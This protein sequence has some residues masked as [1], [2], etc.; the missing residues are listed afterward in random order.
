MFLVEDAFAG[1][2]EDGGVAGP[3]VLEPFGEMEG[4][5]FLLGVR[6]EGEDPLKSPRGGVNR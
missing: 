4:S 1:V 5:C 6:D 2:E 3:E